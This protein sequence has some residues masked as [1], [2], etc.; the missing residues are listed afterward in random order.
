MLIDSLRR[1]AIKAGSVLIYPREW[2]VDGDD[3]VGNLLRAARDLYGARL[4][5]VELQGHNDE[6]DAEVDRTWE[7]SYTKLLAFNQTQYKRVI[8]LDSDASVLQVCSPWLPI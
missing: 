3:D 2:D 8:S 5:P 6:P 7:K 1:V 4:V